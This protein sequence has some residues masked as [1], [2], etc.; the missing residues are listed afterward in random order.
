MSVTGGLAAYAEAL[1]ADP[2]LESWPVVLADVV[3]LHAEGVWQ[4][5]DAA[6]EAAL[7]V[8]PGVAEAGL[9]RLIALAGGRPLTIFGEC[10]HRGFVPHTA[11]SPAAPD[12]AVP[13]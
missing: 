1:C 8:A 9:W 12:E 11:W 3:P 5:A 2:W 10:G 13:L 6:G 4:V 7:P